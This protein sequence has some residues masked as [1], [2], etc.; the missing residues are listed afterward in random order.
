[1]NP[2]NTTF[3][4]DWDRTQFDVNALKR[5]FKK[6]VG[7]EF[8]RGVRFS[9][10]HAQQ[11]KE[12]DN[13]ID[14]SYLLYSDVIQF[15]DEATTEGY[16]IILFSEG[17][18]EGQVFK[19]KL[20]GIQSKYYPNYKKQIYTDKMTNFPAII[21]ALPPNTRLLLFDDKLSILQKASQIASQYPQIDL[22]TVW[23]NRSDNSIQT[24]DNFS[25]DITISTLLEIE[26]YKYI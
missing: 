3:L 19:I 6:T 18:Y 7:T 25:P 11:M 5:L 4:M 13:Q 1:M 10:V 14:G 22:L 20:T 17:D 16:E 21:S 24:I 23:V 12:R 26:K 15:L 8:P 9:N 2:E